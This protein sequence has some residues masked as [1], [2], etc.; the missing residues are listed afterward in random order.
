MADLAGVDGLDHLVGHTQYRAAGKAR[1]NRAAAVDAGERL[2]LGIAAQFQ[3]LFDDR[4]EVL[5][6][7]NM[8]EFRI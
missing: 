1:R 6:R 3:R 8:L 5:V 2:V 7:A 4:R